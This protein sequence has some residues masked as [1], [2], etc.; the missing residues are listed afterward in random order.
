MVPTPKCWDSHN[1]QFATGK[2]RQDKMYNT[3]RNPNTFDLESV[4]ILP[5]YTMNVKT[6]Q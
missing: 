6:G 1:Q 2:M 3:L 4:G 5:F